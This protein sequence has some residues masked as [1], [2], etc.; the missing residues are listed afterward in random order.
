MKDI[1]EFLR[2]SEKDLLIGLSATFGSG[3]VLG[4]IAAAEC[5]RGIGK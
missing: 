3:F 4:L 2:I 5:I 1:S